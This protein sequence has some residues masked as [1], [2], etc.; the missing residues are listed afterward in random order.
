MCGPLAFSCGRSSPWVNTSTA[1]HRYNSLSWDPLG[2]SNSHSH[3]QTPHGSELYGSKCTS[4][5][6]QC[7]FLHPK[8]PL[9][10]FFFPFLVSLHILDWSLWRFVCVEKQP[11]QFCPTLCFPTLLTFADSSGL[12]EILICMFI[13]TFHCMLLQWNCLCRWCSWLISH[14]QMYTLGIT[15]VFSTGIQC[16]QFKEKRPAGL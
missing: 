5:F 13:I 4:G 7:K 10:C 12:L 16:T 6:N 1:L 8:F 14:I 3:S 9:I 11:P 2:F 15:Q